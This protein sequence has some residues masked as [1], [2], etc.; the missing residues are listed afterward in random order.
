[1][2]RQRFVFDAEVSSVFEFNYWFKSSGLLTAVLKIRVII[3][4]WTVARQKDKLF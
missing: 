4:T 3:K 1:M 2:K